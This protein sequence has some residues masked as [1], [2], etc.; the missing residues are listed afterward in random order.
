MDIDLELI[1]T[2]LIRSIDDYARMYSKGPMELDED[3]YWKVMDDQLFDMTKPP[4]SLGVGDLREDF[5]Y[6]KSCIDNDNMFGPLE[7]QYL[8]GLLNWL[9]VKA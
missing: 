4:E 7:M 8:A 1:K 3:Y 6:I 2:A 9:S 5:T